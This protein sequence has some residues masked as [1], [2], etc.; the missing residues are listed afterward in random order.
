MYSV[1]KS[2]DGN[3]FIDEVADKEEFF[4]TLAICRVMPVALPK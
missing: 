1:A 4:I 3:K 2:L